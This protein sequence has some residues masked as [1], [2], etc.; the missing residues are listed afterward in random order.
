MGTI[1][2]LGFRDRIWGIPGSCYNI[3]KAIFYLLKGDYGAEASSR[4][5]QRE[6]LLESLG[7]NFR[8]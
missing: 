1:E 3:P 7:H 6:R 5:F 4:V 2:G 8:T